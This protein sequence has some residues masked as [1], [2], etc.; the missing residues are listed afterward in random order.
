MVGFLPIPD[1][2]AGIDGHAV[3]VWVRRTRHT[4]VRHRFKQKISQPFD[5]PTQLSDFQAQTDTLLALKA[6]FRITFFQE[7][8]QLMGLFF[9][10]DRPAL[11]GLIEGD[12]DID[13]ALADIRID[14]LDFLTKLIF[15]DHGCF[16]FM[17]S[18]F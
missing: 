15:I 11:V 8:L 16:P 2:A 13:A 12:V 6:Q 14:L 17:L 10:V 1:N 5:I 4:R 9:Q 18:R 3:I 7:G